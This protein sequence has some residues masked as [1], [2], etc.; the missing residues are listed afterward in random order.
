MEQ[1]EENSV[2]LKNKTGFQTNG[3]HHK[4]S[5]FLSFLWL[6]DWCPPP[7]HTHTHYIYIYIDLAFLIP[8]LNHFSGEYYY[9]RCYSSGPPVHPV[10]VWYSAHSRFGTLCVCRPGNTTSGSLTWH[11]GL[12]ASRGLSCYCSLNTSVFF[13]VFFSQRCMDG[14]VNESDSPITSLD[15]GLARSWLCLSKIWRWS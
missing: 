7:I 11:K 14:F 6:Y 9:C 5:N 1:T 2:H 4:K 8:T 10:D 12:P 15:V 3:I 13:F